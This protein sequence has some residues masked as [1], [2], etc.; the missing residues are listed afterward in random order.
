MLVPSTSI[1]LAT[2]VGDGATGVSN[3][4]N[5]QGLFKGSAGLISDHAGTLKV[6]RY[7]DAAGLIPVGAALT[8]AL[9]ASVGNAV[10]WS[11]GLPCGSIQVSVINAAGAV[12]NLTNITVN[13][14][15]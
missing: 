14:G 10:G 8:V 2:P 12:A 1:G 9:V 3:V 6:Q 7:A 11:D 15:P 4:I 13:L 5:T